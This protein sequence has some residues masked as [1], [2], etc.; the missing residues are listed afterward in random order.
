MRR[1]LLLIAVLVMVVLGFLAIPSFLP[2]V[3]TSSGKPL[4]VRVQV[5]DQDK[6]PI[7]GATVYG[8]SRFKSAVTGED[9]G[10]E[11]LPHFPA[12]GRV[13]RSGTMDLSGDLQV[14]APGYRQWK[15]SFASLFGYEYDY[16]NHGTVVTQIVVMSK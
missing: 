4:S 13:G 10:C 7:E 12:H 5:V 1:L 14:I 11:I 3:F 2:A 8:P 15:R 9:G 16:F 6:R